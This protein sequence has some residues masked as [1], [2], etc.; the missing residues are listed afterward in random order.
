[1]S[2]HRPSEGLLTPK[3]RTFLQE[4]WESSRPSGG[5]PPADVPVGLGARPEAEEYLNRLDRLDSELNRLF[6]AE[7][8]PETGVRIAAGVSAKLEA[9]S[10]SAGL[11]RAWWRS[12]RVAW[13][14]G[15]VACL[16]LGIGLG[17]L[18]WRGD[19]KGL[20]LAMGE[21]PASDS[22]YAYYDSEESAPPDDTRAKALANDF[23]V[24]SAPGEP[25]A[26]R[27][28]ALSQR[29]SNADSMGTRVMSAPAPSAS[30]HRQA[31]APEM[32]SDQGSA[33]MF[34]A[35]GYELRGGMPE[36][37]IGRSLPAGGLGGGVATAR[38]LGMEQGSDHL[39]GGDGFGEW[40]NT[41]PAG[42]PMLI[43]RG[44]QQWRLV[45]PT[46][47]SYEVITPEAI[48]RRIGEQSQDRRALPLDAP[49][50][51]TYQF[52]APASI[53]KPAERERTPRIVNGEELGVLS[54]ERQQGMSGDASDL[55][56]N[57]SADEAGQAALAMTA[58]E[59]RLIVRGRREQV[60]RLLAVLGLPVERISGEAMLPMRTS[61][62]AVDI[63]R[64]PEP[65]ERLSEA[66]SHELFSG[67]PDEEIT[68]EI[69]WKGPEGEVG[70]GEDSRRDAEALRE[71]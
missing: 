8:S 20:D 6:G 46:G 41:G 67:P 26:T 51:L 3:E 61:P 13:A 15:L 44:G 4:C 30:A 71:E 11:F 24:E 45:I 54:L 29:E 32:P 52:E 35:A 66:D 34:G 58:A 31:A 28:Y 16:M 68:L 50:S 22:D 70:S 5:P 14:C 49:D 9:E 27:G 25:S 43:A 38:S 55:E 21:R 42:G 63:K 23:D 59:P 40:D 64:E 65:Q 19:S 7:V 10:E 33:P 1:M 37:G 57:T 69:H 48:I 2:E 53:G 60:L 18:L 12:E 56:L 39:F 47:D 36:S 62:S 17:W